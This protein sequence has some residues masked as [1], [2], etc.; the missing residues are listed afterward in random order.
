ML[1]TQLVFQQKCAV[2][3][4]C[5]EQDSRV[6]PPNPISM[7]NRKENACLRHWATFSPSYFC[8]GS[9]EAAAMIVID[10]VECCLFPPLMHYVKSCFHI[11]LWV[12]SDLILWGILLWWLQSDS[13]LES[14]QQS[15]LRC[16]GTKCHSKIFK[17]PK[18][19]NLFCSQ[20]KTMKEKGFQVFR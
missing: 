5:P 12:W 2:H 15:L 13:H 19:E 11:C 9:D 18:R 6:S 8:M 3:Q 1:W 20:L 16:R 4:K 14:A 7:P 17:V 10:R